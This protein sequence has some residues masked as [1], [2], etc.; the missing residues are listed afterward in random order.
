MKDEIVRCCECR[1]YQREDVA[2]TRHPGSKRWYCP[3][4]W[5]TTGQFRAAAEIG[6][7]EREKAQ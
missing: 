2:F 7:A 1:A 3:E 5:D 4:C 6:S